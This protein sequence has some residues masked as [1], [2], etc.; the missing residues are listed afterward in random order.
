MPWFIGD[1]VR[2]TMHLDHVQDGAYRSLIDA[3]W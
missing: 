2:D 1:H 3:R